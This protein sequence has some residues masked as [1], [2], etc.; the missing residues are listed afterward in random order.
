M[1]KTKEKDLIATS[2]LWIGSMFISCGPLTHSTVASHIVKGSV[3]FD[4]NISN[5]GIHGSKHKVTCMLVLAGDAQYVSE[6]R[7]H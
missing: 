7:M 5:M 3:H 1:P 6:I 2:S 4:C